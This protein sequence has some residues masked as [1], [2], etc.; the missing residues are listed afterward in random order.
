MRFAE[1]SWL[2]G[3][4]LALVVA[5]ALTWGGW[6]HQRAVR[7]FGDPVLVTG[8][9][10]AKTGTRRAIRAVLLVL[11]LCL[12][13]VAA[14]QPQ[15]GRGTRLIPATNLDVVLVLDFSKS[16]YARDVTPSRSA[17]AKVEMSQLIR[18]LGGARF[19]G[20]A[21][22]GTPMSF[23]LT[24]DGAA[25]AQFFRGL[26]PNDMPVGG[27]AIARALDAARQLLERDPKSKKHERVAV[28]VTDGEDLEGDPVALAEAMARD[29]ITVHV[30]QIGG[31]SPEPIPEV[32]EHGQL[33]GLR[34]DSSGQLL[35][36]ALTAEGEA[37]LA[38]IAAKGG[39]K[40][41]RAEKG[42][43]GVEEVARELRRMMTEELSEQVETIYADVY[44]YPLGLALVLIL[45]ET[46]IGTAPN[47]KPAL[48]SAPPRRARRRKRASSLASTTTAA[49][50][51]SSLLG[52]ERIEST[53]DAIFERYSP[54]VDEAIETLHDGRPAAALTLLTEYLETGACEAG[55]IGTPE[56]SARLPDAAF[57][58]GLALFEV[59]DTTPSAR[60]DPD[61]GPTPPE[62][63]PGMTGAAPEGPTPAQR[64]HIDCALR[65]LGPIALNTSLPLALRA[66]AHYL[67]GNLELLRKEHRA[68]IAAYDAALRLIPGL[69]EPGPDEPAIDDI[70][71]R[72]A[73]NRAVALRRLAEEPP[74]DQKSDNDPEAGEQDEQ[75]PP[76]E[77]EE[78]EDSEDEPER[79]DEGDD[80][81]SDH[82]DQDQS[83]DQDQD[84]DQ[85]PEGTE[86]P[87]ES[88]GDD[89]SP[90]PQEGQDQ[91]SPPPDPREERGRDAAPE[92][93]ASATDPSRERD[94]R[95]L[96]E[97]ERAPTFQQHDAR[98]N[99]RRVRGSIRMEDK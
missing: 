31:R 45:I 98:D 62:L 43:T 5:L 56:R 7:R 52:C 77:G 13:F 9:K 3:M 87:D 11:A 20:V 84:Q 58:L 72:A 51:A 6:S 66:R 8:L 26:E 42:T 16:M 40:L 70:G 34:Q 61:S 48:P 17:R 67:T 44:A 35:T 53:L 85:D 37:Q 71:R 78:G 49:L 99:A 88:S 94:E 92:Q 60:P 86:Q 63:P 23:P 83:Q 38:Q 93:A 79:Q 10:T 55:V 12:V 18:E 75:D 15:Y 21:F 91:A 22:A 74:E 97:F 39:G 33:R 54:T 47:R 32:D 25:V 24:S 59:S 57:D 89:A 36:T 19:G 50:L 90:K 65:V 1:A 64:E 73:H 28:L 41:V 14:A 76:E 46:M 68:A 2:W 96:D 95:L 69:P 81:S 30:V 4:V 82:Q 80:E 29:R 27:T